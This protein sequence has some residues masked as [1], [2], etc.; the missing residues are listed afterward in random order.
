MKKALFLLSFL[1]TTL[2]FSQSI[3]FEG[4]VQDSLKRPLEMANVMAV[5]LDTKAM[6]GYSITN[7]KGLSL[8]HI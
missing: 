7:D 8:I 5:N 1:Y 6:D 3:K 4:V 2:S